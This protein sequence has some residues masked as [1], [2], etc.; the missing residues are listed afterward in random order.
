MSKRGRSANDRYY[1]KMVNPSF[2]LSIL[3]NSFRIGDFGLPVEL[4]DC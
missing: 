2:S 4:D 3:G 1:G